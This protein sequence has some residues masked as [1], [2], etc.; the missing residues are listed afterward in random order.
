MHHDLRPLLPNRIKLLL[1]LVGCLA[2]LFVLSDYADFFQRLVPLEQDDGT[3]DWQR[4]LSLMG[5]FGAFFLISLFWIETA[6]PPSPR[7]SRDAFIADLVE[8][9][10]KGAAA[11]FVVDL[12]SE[13][14][15]S[16]LAHLSR[17]IEEAFGERRVTF[18][19]VR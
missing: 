18:F 6:P 14:E 3:V 15:E 10:G 12:K 5:A 19:R 2:A 11:V 1:I 13:D 9:R 16:E 7:M 17:Q 4:A 8:R